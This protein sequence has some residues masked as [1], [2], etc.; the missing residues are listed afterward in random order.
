M[1]AACIFFNA[2]RQRTFGRESTLYTYEDINLILNEIVLAILLVYQSI[3]W[4]ISFWESFVI[5]LGSGSDVSEVRNVWLHCPEVA[6][7]GRYTNKM[8]VVV[9]VACKRKAYL[10][11]AMPNETILVDW[12]WHC[13]SE[14]KLQYWWVW[15]ISAWSCS[16]TGY[17]DCYCYFVCAPQKPTFFG[18][19]PF[20]ASWQGVG[21]KN[22]L[23]IV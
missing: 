11:I 2:I 13:L 3:M 19:P 10:G 4:W 21:R 16:L 14:R 15:W 1:W 17:E 22:S 5:D 9:E 23:Y 20:L 8:V 12:V 7:A 6:Y 18:R